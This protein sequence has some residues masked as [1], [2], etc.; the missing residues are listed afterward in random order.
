MLSSPVLYARGP[1]RVIAS[2]P[3]AAERLYVVVDTAGAWLREEP[4]FETARAWVD[5]RL[6]DR[7]APGRRPDAPGLAR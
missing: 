1:Y 2:D 7:D 5:H 6:V 4:S 3:D